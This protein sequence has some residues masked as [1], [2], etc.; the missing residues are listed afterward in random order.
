[1]R[2]LIVDDSPDIRLLLKRTLQVAGYP[3]VRAVATGEEALTLLGVGTPE[4][5]PVDLI[6][7]DLVMPGIDGI[8]V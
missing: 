4:V 3:E 5:S 6:L 2:I 8:S 1:M 7:L